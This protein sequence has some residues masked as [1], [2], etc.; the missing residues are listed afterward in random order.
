MNLP[1]SPI[2][3]RSLIAAG[4]AKHQAVTIARYDDVVA[5]H[6]DDDVIAA[7]GGSVDLTFQQIARRFEIRLAVA[8]EARC[9]ARSRRPRGS[10]TDRA[11][12]QTS[13]QLEVRLPSA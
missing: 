9:S 13:G 8:P 7:Y 3:S 4:R 10:R 12:I 6:R 5:A 1:L 11:A 2:T